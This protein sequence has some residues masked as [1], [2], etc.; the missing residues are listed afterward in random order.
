MRNF[1]IGWIIFQLVVIGIACV[2]IDNQVNQG[3]YVCPTKDKK[4]SIIWGA[5]F[6]LAAFVNEPQSLKDYCYKNRSL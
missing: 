2:D 1:L 3:T 6:P 5:V 4:V